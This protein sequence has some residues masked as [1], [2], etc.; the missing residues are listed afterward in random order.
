MERPRIHRCRRVSVHF[1]HDAGGLLFPL[2]VRL[3]EAPPRGLAG[4]RM[5]LLAPHQGPDSRVH[6]PVAPKHRDPSLPGLRLA[7]PDRPGGKAGRTPHC[8]LVGALDRDDPLGGNPLGDLLHGVRG[9]RGIPPGKGGLEGR[10]ALLVA[11]HVLYHRHQRNHGR[12]VFGA[13]PA[14]QDSRDCH[15]RR[16]RRGFGQN[17]CSRH[18]RR[19][20]PESFG[21]QRN[22][23][24]FLGTG[25]TPHRNNPVL[26]PGASPVDRRSRHLHSLLS[27]KPGRCVLVGCHRGGD[28]DRHRHVSRRHIGL[29]QVRRRCPGPARSLF[30]RRRQHRPQHRR[31]R[32]RPGRRRDGGKF[33]VGGA[34]SGREPTGTVSLSVCLSLSPARCECACVCAC[35]LPSRAAG[36]AMIEY[37]IQATTRVRMDRVVVS[38][39]GHEYRIV[40][41]TDE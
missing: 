40:E 38:T 34:G 4:R 27:R 18:A 31:R 37:K 3:Q 20:L 21:E 10:Q 2:H 36:K 16:R 33:R 39:T 8:S 22:L 24:D 17:T 25:T 19:Y 29:G 12:R 7:V 23:R 11:R 15:R 14:E 5:D 32:R 26:W 41:R 35:V 30:G 9:P 6:A 1:S 28:R 13:V